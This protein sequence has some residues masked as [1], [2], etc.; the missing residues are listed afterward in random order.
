MSHFVRE[1]GGG[2]GSKRAVPRRNAPS[3]RSAACAGAGR[4]PTARPRTRARASSGASRSAGGAAGFCKVVD[5]GF[6]LAVEAG[7]RRLLARGEVALLGV[8]R[9]SLRVRLVRGEGRGVSD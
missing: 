3:A 9:P 2:G 6:P 5:L 4:R 7:D 8:K 1:G